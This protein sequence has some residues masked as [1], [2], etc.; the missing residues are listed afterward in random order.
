[1]DV[2]ARAHGGS[3]HVANVEGGVDVWLL[4]PR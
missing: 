4:L 1:V 3:A 2:I